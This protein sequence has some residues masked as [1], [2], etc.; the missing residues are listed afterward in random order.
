MMDSRG[1]SVQ[2]PSEVLEV[3]KISSDWVD[4]K[5]ET[6]TSGMRLET[7][8]KELH[9]YYSDSE[10]SEIP[11]IEITAD[12]AD[13]VDRAICECMQAAADFWAANH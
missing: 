11:T 12:N 10:K 5:N 2:V 6:T 4:L 13:A 9:P 3:V 1:R 8:L 7:A